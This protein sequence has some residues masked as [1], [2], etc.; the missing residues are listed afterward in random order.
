MKR[1]IIISAALLLGLWM[2]LQSQPVSAPFRMGGPA[3]RRP[4]GCSAGQVWLASDTGT[5]S[6]CQAPGNPGTWSVLGGG[7]PT[8]LCTVANG[9][10]I[11]FDASQCSA[12][13]LTLG[14][15]MP[16]T[17]NLIGATSGQAL[18]F[19]ITDAN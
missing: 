16:S 15:S 8:G 5:L 13:S 17:V 6:Y 2:V 11:T 18:T 10:S 14:A 4:S 3:A 19:L 7:Y 9:S 1:T 12:F